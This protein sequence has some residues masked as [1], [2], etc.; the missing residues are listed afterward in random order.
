[1]EHAEAGYKTSLKEKDDYQCLP[2]CEPTCS[3]GSLS[4]DT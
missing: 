4:Q 2:K 3:Q 1:M